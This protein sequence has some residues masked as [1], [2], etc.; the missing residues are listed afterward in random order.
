MLRLRALADRRPK[1]PDFSET[2]FILAGHSG[3]HGTSATYVV[4]T[5]GKLRSGY[6]GHHADAPRSDAGGRRAVPFHG[7]GGETVSRRVALQAKGGRG[8]RHPW[9]MPEEGRA[10]KVRRARSSE[11]TATHERSG[12]RR[13]LGHTTASLDGRVNGKVVVQSSQPAT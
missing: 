8:D 10:C 13:L 6:Q 5:R 7:Y 12:G 2:P 3:G 9:P 4:D 11:E 1:A